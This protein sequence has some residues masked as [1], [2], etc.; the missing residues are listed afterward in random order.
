MLN[1][2]VARLYIILCRVGDVCDAEGFATLGAGAAGA[3][4]FL[5]STIAG[6]CFPIVD[7][8]FRA[9]HHDVAFGKMGVWRIQLHTIVSARLHGFAHGGD[10]VGSAVGINGVVAAMISHHHNFQSTAFG[11]SASYRE[12][13]AVAERHHGAFHV[14][15]VV[16]AA[17]NGVGAAEQRRGKELFHECQIDDDMLYA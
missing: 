7:A 1:H 13:N 14:V 8:E 11:K 12:H 15:I 3:A 2:E 16:V 4:V 10:E 5:A 6:I 9:S 17:G